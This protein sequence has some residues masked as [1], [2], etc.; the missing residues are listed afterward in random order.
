MPWIHS[1]LRIHTSF[2]ARPIDSHLSK[3][4]MELRIILLKKSYLVCASPPNG[5]FSPCPSRLID[6]YLSGLYRFPPSFFAGSFTTHRTGDGTARKKNP[7]RPSV[8][9]TTLRTRYKFHPLF[10]CFSPTLKSTDSCWF[11]YKII[12]T[13]NTQSRRKGR[14]ESCVE[15]SLC[16][17]QTK[18]LG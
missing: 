13:T 14:K 7:R 10:F 2:T 4:M 6:Y 1:C 16:S 18:N 3:W 8:M 15:L 5:R 12:S 17:W 9:S 11:G